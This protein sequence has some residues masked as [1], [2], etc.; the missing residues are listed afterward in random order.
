MTDHFSRRRILRR[1]ARLTDVSPEIVRAEAWPRT[2]AG[3]RIRAALRR[4]KLVVLHYARW[5]DVTGF[6]DDLSVDLTTAEPSM[7]V[8]RLDLSDPLLREPPGA[9]SRLLAIVSRHADVPLPSAAAWPMAREGFRFGLQSIF[10]AAQ[11]GPRRVLLAERG[12]HVPWEVLADMAQAWNDW[13]STRA[14]S[15]SIRML[16][17]T[18]GQ[19][20]GAIPK[21]CELIELPDFGHREAVS[22]LVG[23]LG[24]EKAFDATRVVDALGPV[25]ELLRQIVATGSLPAIGT[26]DARLAAW[27]RELRRVQ[28]AVQIARST[29][30]LA[31]RLDALEAGPQPWDSAADPALVL[32][33]LAIRRAG[34]RHPLTAVRSPTLALFVT[35]PEETPTIDDAP[36]SGQ[37]PKAI[38]RPGRSTRRP[39]VDP[40]LQHAKTES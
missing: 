30:A 14:E 35:S 29:E 6:L 28:E 9:W 26:P 8:S 13:A 32:A 2:R 18:R 20:P 4:G 33:G 3:R 16:V 22:H 40:R 5:S 36:P 25:P 31:A 11:N 17:S 7:L 12:H 39:G 15:A 34:G 27:G 21:D 23:W 19:V 10:E 38:G 37:R 1:G 24:V